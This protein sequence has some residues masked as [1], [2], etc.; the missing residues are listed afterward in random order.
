MQHWY[1]NFGDSSRLKGQSNRIEV[2]LVRLDRIDAY[3]S[4]SKNGNQKINYKKISR[5]FLTAAFI[6]KNFKFAAKNLLVMKIKMKKTDGTMMTTWE[7]Q[8]IQLSMTVKCFVDDSIHQRFFRCILHK[9]SISY[10]T[11]PSSFKVSGQCLM[12]TSWHHMRLILPRVIKN[13]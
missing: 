9:Q 13:L 2:R 11:P 1:Y 10:I 4:D 12:K 3:K 5:F 8:P 6:L 7:I